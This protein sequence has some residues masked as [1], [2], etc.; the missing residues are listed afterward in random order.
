MRSRLRSDPRKVSCN[1]SVSS[2]VVQGQQLHMIRRRK[3]PLITLIVVA[4][5]TESNAIPRKIDG[6]DRSKLILLESLWISD[7]RGGGP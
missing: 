4:T 6:K 5:L 1:S 7:L 3:F 2:G